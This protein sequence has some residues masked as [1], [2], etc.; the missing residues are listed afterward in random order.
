MS[1]QRGSWL[2]IYLPLVE[3]C[4]SL[5]A[6]G[7]PYNDVQ[8]TSRVTNFN[9]CCATLPPIP[10]LN[11]DG[12]VD[13]A[14]VQPGNGFCPSRFLDTGYVLKYPG[15]KM[16]DVPQV[17]ND[18]PPLCPDALYWRSLLEDSLKA[19]G[20]KL[21]TC[22]SLHPF[23]RRYANAFFE[24]SHAGVA[25]LGSGRVPDEAI[26]AAQ[27]TIR[28]MMRQTT[29]QLALHCPSCQNFAQSIAS[30]YA[31]FTLWSDQERSFNNCAVCV[32]LCN[33]AETA[34]D[35]MCC[36]PGT[37]RLFPG[38]TSVGTLNCSDDLTYMRSQEYKICYEGKDGSA[39]P[40]VPLCTEPGGADPRD[41][42][43]GTEELG[44]CYRLSNGTVYPGYQGR[45]IVIEEW[46]HT[47]HGLGI[48]SVDP[49]GYAMIHDNAVRLKEA[50]V[51][52]SKTSK[53][54]AYDRYAAN[55]FEFMA[56][57]VQ[58][59]HGFPE[60]TGYFAYQS[61]A[62]IKRRDPELARL[63]LRYFEDSD[64]NPCAGIVIDSPRPQTNA[65]NKGFFGVNPNHKKGELWKHPD[66][67]VQAPGASCSD[68][69]KLAP[70]S[71][72]C[73]GARLGPEYVGPPMLD[74][75]AQTV[76]V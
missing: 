1:R 68:P 36:S 59:W 62:E 74:A 67:V 43:A 9:D 34:P 12:V 73:G 17:C 39:M 71:A 33:S 13:G 58:T 38:N 10:L 16:E 4:P 54:H 75:N 69:C 55:E 2:A 44:V 66:G 8:T 50:G 72:L 35:Q 63:I 57:A 26:L 70:G 24:D 52:M 42:T 48:Q 37:S 61:R 30:K 5:N 19:S 51:W 60:W 22:Q 11:T 28:E 45:N 25:V 20:L 18:D 65:C 46:F 29:K 3:A 41:A 64:W 56:M 7:F 6:C 21:S 23:Y 53:G 32:N 49:V 40:N 47:M 14:H 27:R 15:L 31:R 76:L